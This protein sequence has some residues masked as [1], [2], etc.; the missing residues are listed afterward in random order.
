[1][2]DQAAKQ[3][4]GRRRD[5]AKA[6]QEVLP[7]VEVAVLAVPPLEAPGPKRRENKRQEKQKLEEFRA[8]FSRGYA[9]ILAELRK[10]RELNEKATGSKM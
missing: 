3:R 9:V 5:E 2:A 4:R 10:R 6:S 1:M 8:S 7:A